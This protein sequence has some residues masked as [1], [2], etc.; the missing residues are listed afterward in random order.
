MQFNLEKCTVIHIGRSYPHYENR[1]N[2][3]VL[4]ATEEEKD[5]GSVD[6]QKPETFRIVLKSSYKRESSPKP[7]VAEFPLP[8]PTHLHE[9]V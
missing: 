5:N 1:M 4:S 2:R 8:G 9:A 3:V 6:H 7:A